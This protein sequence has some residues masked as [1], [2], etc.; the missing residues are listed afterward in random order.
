[1]DHDAAFNRFELLLLYRTLNR[2]EDQLRDKPPV[3]GDA[4]LAG[5][6]CIDMRIIVL[7]IGAKSER[8]EG[9]P[10]LQ[11][12]AVSLGRLFEYL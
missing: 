5:K 1:V 6:S 2:A 9:S 12:R 3:G 10:D 11:Q 7:Q 8:R 4:P